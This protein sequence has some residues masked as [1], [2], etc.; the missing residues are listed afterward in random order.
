MSHTSR[1]TRPVQ[2]LRSSNLFFVPVLRQRLSFAVLVQEALHSLELDSEWSASEDLIAV[3]LPKSVEPSLRVAITRLEETDNPGISLI[4]AHVPQVGSRE[5]FPVTPCDAMIEGARIAYERHCPIEFIDLELSPAN[6]LKGPCIKDPNWADDTLTSLIG[7]EKYLDLVEPYFSVPPA[8]FEPLDTWREVFIAQRLKSLSPLWRRILVVCDAGLVRP[9]QSR[10]RQ[11]LSQAITQTNNLKP[12]PWEFKTVQQLNLSTLLSYLDDYPRLVERYEDARNRGKAHLFRKDR[13]LMDVVLAFAD[14][15][16]DLRLSTRQ[17]QTFGAFV[18]NILRF[19]RRLCPNPS[20]LY[21]AA[22][23][24]YGRAFGERLYC[25]LAGYYTHIRAER[26]ESPRTNVISY[27]VGLSPSLEK[28]KTRSC[29]PATTSYREV[30]KREPRPQERERS[31]SFFEWSPQQEHKIAM[32]SKLQQIV[33]RTHVKNKAKKYRGSI[34]MGIDVRRTIR[35]RFHGEQ[36]LYVKSVIP[37]QEQLATDR[38]P[39]LW[40][41]SE[42]FDHKWGVQSGHIGMSNRGKFTPSTGGNFLIGYMEFLEE[43][44][45]GVSPHRLSFMED[46]SQ[47]VV[48]MQR[49]GLLAFATNCDTEEQAKNVYGDNLEV[50]VP[51]HADFEHPNGCVHRDLTS[52]AS[53]GASWA[54]IAL[55][56]AIKYAE[57]AVVIV[58]PP[59]LPFAARLD[60]IASACGKQLVYVSTSSF[61]RSDLQKLTTTYF[62]QSHG[63]PDAESE[64]A[65][66]IIMRSYWN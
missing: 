31:N 5:I 35:A 18:K 52:L 17:H 56:T 61:S 33:A 26:V 34:E 38:E 4:V 46:H 48:Y 53:E 6:L 36:G 15:T 60:A 44:S 3:V 54:E 42:E 47:N 32:Q 16:R 41:L 65:F 63:E 19:E 43:D 29:N 11:P 64:R 37:R 9:I 22:S 57:R 25:Y 30:K 7:I 12:I 49:C 1:T 39:I 51:N 23:A 50:R 62:Y 58:A 66:S 13:E 59:G 40:I 8:R 45:S 14:G 21:E 28:Y 2:Y 55:R 27:K 20:T 10:L 24:C